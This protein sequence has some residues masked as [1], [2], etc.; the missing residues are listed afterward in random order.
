MARYTSYTILTIITFILTHSIHLDSNHQHKNIKKI[1][2]GSC[3]NLRYP[4]DYLQNIINIKPDIWLWIGDTVYGKTKHGTDLSNIANDYKRL[5]SHSLYQ[6]FLKT[7]VTI[8]GVYDDHDIGMNDADNRLLKSIQ[9]QSQ[10]LLLDF[11]DINANDIRRQRNGVYSVHK[12]TDIMIILLDTR[13]HRSPTIIPS[14]GKYEYP[15]TAFIASYTRYLCAYFGLI[16]DENKTVLGKQQWL[17]LKKILKSDEYKSSK[18]VLIVSSTQIFTSNPYFESWGHFVN[19]KKK[20]LQLMY[21]SID[22]NDNKHVLFISGDVHHAEII[23]GNKDYGPL[24]V[25]ASGMTHSLGTMSRV[26]GLQKFLALHI[27]NFYESFHR[28]QY[29]N[30]VNGYYERNFGMI[31]ISDDDKYILNIYDANSGKKVICVPL[32][33]NGTSSFKDV[34]K[35]VMND[36]DKMYF[37]RGYPFFGLEIIGPMLGL[38]VVGIICVFGIKKM[39]R[40]NVK[41]KTKKQL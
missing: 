20:L 7:N 25:T 33:H 19:E 35:D 3:N 27:V 24:E 31:E 34:L 6:K 16:S 1:A 5:K 17:W 12:F 14:I 22:G 38:V 8:D 29:G 28:T 15:F 36:K 26:W 37:P 23:Y 10:T 30:V 40:E 9:Q 2:F 18:L 4:L 32:N 21:D 41:S 13:T 11:L 39:T